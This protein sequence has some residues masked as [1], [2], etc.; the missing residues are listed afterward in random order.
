M[1]TILAICLLGQC[2]PCR[3]FCEAVPNVWYQSP[4]VNRERSVGYWWFMYAPNTW[5]QS[6]NELRMARANAPRPQLSSE[7]QANLN[8]LSS[9][10]DQLWLKLIESSKED[11]PLI[12]EEYLKAKYRLDLARLSASRKLRTKFP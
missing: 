8:N 11:K 12:R 6:V 7:D 2:E 5:N 1:N 9:E 10:K 3:P 4:W